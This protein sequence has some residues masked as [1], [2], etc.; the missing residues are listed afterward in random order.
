[1]LERVSG[2][3]GWL[4]VSL[5]RAETAL[6]SRDSMVIAAST[7]DGQVLAQDTAER[8]FQ[9][10][11]TTSAVDVAYPADTMAAIDGEAMKAAQQEAENQS[12]KWLDE[13]TVKL[14]AYA[15]D[16]ES[17]NKRREKELKAEADA[18]KRALRGNQSMPL[19]EKIVEERRIKKLEQERDDLVFDSFK[20]LREI[21]REIDDKLNDVAAKLAITPKITPLMTIRWE[22]TA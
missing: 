22:L 8:L 11:A 15:E 9:V 7:D 21:H 1:M 5:L 18:A 19:A 6:G 3:A 14:E 20:K 13:E 4:K 17:A 12:R 10:P 16:L 2:K